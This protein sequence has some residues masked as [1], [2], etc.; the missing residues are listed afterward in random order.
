MPKE[1][2]RDYEVV[3]L[4]NKKEVAKQI[5]KDNI[6]RLNRIYFDNVACDEI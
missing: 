4:K 5:V 3:F 1:L 2:V 6:Q